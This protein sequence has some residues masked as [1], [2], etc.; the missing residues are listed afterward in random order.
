MHVQLGGR[1]MTFKQLEYFIAFASQKNFTT[2][3]ATC[4]TTQPNLM[5]Q[6][7]KLEDEF[8]KK[9]YTRTGT[10]T[11]LTKAG[12]VLNSK[13]AIITGLYQELVKQ[14]AS[15][16]FCQEITFGYMMDCTQIEEIKERIG[17]FCAS[18]MVKWQHGS[19]E[20]LL[21]SGEMDICFTYRRPKS[22]SLAF[23]T[24]PG[25]KGVPVKGVIPC[26]MEYDCEIM[27]INDLASA[28]ILLPGPPDDILSSFCTNFFK[29]HRINPNIAYYYSHIYDRSEY[30]YKLVKEKQIGIAPANTNELFSKAVRFIELEKFNYE[31][32]LKLVWNPRKD[33]DFE[34]IINELSLI[35]KDLP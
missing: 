29:Q 7:Q 20:K 3:A 6:I 18:Y 19:D 8:G 35:L 33:I 11:E 25:L 13:G 14:M 24:L 12:E 23:K 4:F 27:R 28:N 9:L 34:R 5:R 15:P 32:P 31:L 22:T 16:D 1:H 26:S 21:L 30:Y 17:N 2:A 10:T